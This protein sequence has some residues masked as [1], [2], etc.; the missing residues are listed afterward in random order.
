MIHYDT[1]IITDL[2]D[3]RVSLP[4]KPNHIVT[5][6]RYSGSPTAHSCLQQQTPCSAEPNGI[7][8]EA[9]HA[10]QRMPV[11]TGTQPRIPLHEIGVLM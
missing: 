9:F 1:V 6:S 2:P 7:G 4:E 5:T 8:G 3:L 10:E 11:R